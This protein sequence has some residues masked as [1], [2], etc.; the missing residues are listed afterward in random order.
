MP[1]WRWRRAPLLRDSVAV[2]MRGFALLAPCYRRER[3][4]KI[5]YALLLPDDMSAWRLRHGVAALMFL[6]LFRLYAAAQV[7]APTKH[8]HMILRKRW[9][10]WQN[11]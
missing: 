8:A 5:L 1:L 4:A 2:T 9:R 6:R 11:R 7:T 10:R 3:H